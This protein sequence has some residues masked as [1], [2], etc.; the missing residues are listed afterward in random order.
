LKASYDLSNFTGDARAIAIAL[1][2]YGMMLADNGSDWY[3][4]GETNTSW[5][6]NNLDQ[7]KN[8]RGSAFEV[9]QTGPLI[10]GY[11]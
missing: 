9:V 1:K 7:L 5:V 2:T 10:T 4:T 3:V 8:I 6:D 11:C